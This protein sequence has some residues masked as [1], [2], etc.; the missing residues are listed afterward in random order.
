VE[1]SPLVHADAIRTPL[2][3]LHAELDRNCPPSQSSE[4]FTALRRLGR[5]VRYLRARETGHLMNF[6]GSAAFRAARA[7]AI[8]AWLDTWLAADPGR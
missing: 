1:R 8:D 6:T 5:T 3:L 4:L 2:L 7:D